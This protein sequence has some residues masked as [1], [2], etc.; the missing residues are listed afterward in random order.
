MPVGGSVAV[1]DVLRLSAAVLL[2]VAVH[3]GGPVVAVVDGGS[4]GSG[5]V[6]Q[7]CGVLRR[8]LH[9]AFLRRAGHEVVH[10]DGYADL[11]A[12]CDVSAAGDGFRL[13]LDKVAEHVSARL[14]DVERVDVVAL[15]SA[16]VAVVIV[17]GFH[18]ALSVYHVHAHEVEAVV[19]AL[20]LE[21]DGLLAGFLEGHIAACGDNLLARGCAVAVNVDLENLGGCV[22]ARRP[23]EALGCPRLRREAL[24][25]GVLGLGRVDAHRGF[26]TCEDF[27][28]YKHRAACVAHHGGHGL[29][30]AVVYGVKHR[31]DALHSDVAARG[32]DVHLRA[33]VVRAVAQYGV[34]RHFKSVLGEH[35]LDGLSVEAVGAFHCLC[36]AGKVF[37]LYALERHV[38]GRERRAVA[39][40]HLEEFCA[41]LQVHLGAAVK[42]E[43]SSGGAERGREQI[44]G[45]HVLAARSREGSRAGL[46][47]L[48]EDD[49]LRP[50]VRG[51]ASQ[52]QSSDGRE[53]PVAQIVFFHKSDYEVIYKV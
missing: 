48:R 15:Q 2:C 49:R 46:R 25:A 36:V 22:A 51:G 27:V 4:G 34:P 24:H 43:L 1:D 11:L 35:G 12:E 23:Y 44:V 7:L 53:R 19:A 40:H 21:G 9:S 17:G 3:G 18:V 5:G 30:R 32:G 41:C 10:Y 33:Q 14:G 28:A 29:R 37:R 47:L 38:G 16:R 42:E 50:E 39:K 20:V 52:H 8:R 13:C 45:Q 6:K 31:G 26:E